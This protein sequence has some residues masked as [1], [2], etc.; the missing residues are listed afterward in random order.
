MMPLEKR[1]VDKRTLQDLFNEARY[2][3]RVDTGEFS[4]EV[5]YDGA[6]DPAYGQG[7]STRSQRVVIRDASGAY[8]ATVHRYLR[9]D[10]SIGGSG[11]L[12]PTRVRVG[13]IIYTLP[14]P[15]DRWRLWDALK[16]N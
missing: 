13:N 9:A 16:R 4:E 3:D 10:Y 1:F 7:A 11:L 15:K 2:Q 12:D 5:V 6:P 8:M 14:P